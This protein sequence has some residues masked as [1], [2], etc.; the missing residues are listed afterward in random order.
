MFFFFLMIRR[1]PRSTRTDTRFPYTTL[2][3]SAVAMLASD[4]RNMVS[5][6]TDSALTRISVR[7]HGGVLAEESMGGHPGR[8]AQKSPRSGLRGRN[9]RRSAPF[10]ADR[11]PDS[12]SDGLAVPP[13]W[14]PGLFEPP[15]PAQP[16]PR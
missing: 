14:P 12:P 8:Q 3:R 5:E 2:F 10:L 6:T 1:P 7:R 13:E 4:G 15:A 9:K 16:C 11:A